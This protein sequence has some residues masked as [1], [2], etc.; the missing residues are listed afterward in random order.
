[1]LAH[2][3]R[4]FSRALVKEQMAASFECT[5]PRNGDLPREDSRVLERG[6]HV[7]GAVQDK[8]RDRHGR[9]TLE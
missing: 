1:V 4:G 6:D 9:Q 8:G 3:T 5:Q 7:F 2:D